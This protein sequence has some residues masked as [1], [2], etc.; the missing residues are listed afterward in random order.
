LPFQQTLCQTFRQS[1]MTL[2]TDWDTTT[3]SRW[4]RRTA[5][6]IQKLGFPAGQS[7]CR[8][9]LVLRTLQAWH[10]IRFG[11][12]ILCR[13]SGIRA[14]YERQPWAGHADST[15]EPDQ[16]HG[17]KYG[18][19]FALLINAGSNSVWARLTAQRADN[20]ARSLGTAGNGFTISLLHQ[21]LAANAT[22]LT[23]Q[24]ARRRSLVESMAP[25]ADPNGSFWR[26]DLT[27]TPPINRAA[28]DWSSLSSRH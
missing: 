2:A 17:R 8:S 26:T 18:I 10:A 6:L 4:R 12:D 23:V 3:R 24:P 7:L 22:P 25:C 13:Q 9:A 16:R 5:W 28:R 20:T 21:Q 14:D 19:C 27:A 11:N 15:R 1:T